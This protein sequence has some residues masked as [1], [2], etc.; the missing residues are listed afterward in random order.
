MAS[1]PVLGKEHFLGLPDCRAAL[2][3]GSHTEQVTSG[4]SANLQALSITGKVTCVT[5]PSQF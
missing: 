5:P 4:K 3:S 2:P 1:S